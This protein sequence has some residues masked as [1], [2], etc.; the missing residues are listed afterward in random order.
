[1]RKLYNNGVFNLTVEP[2][3]ASPN[4]FLDCVMES[5]AVS[6]RASGFADRGHT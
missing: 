1:M 4:S 5:L 2:L 6:V 3:G